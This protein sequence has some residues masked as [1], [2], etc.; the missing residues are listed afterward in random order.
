MVV[1]LPAELEVHRA[2]ARL[3]RS[4]AETIT[5]DNRRYRDRMRV[6]M[7]VVIGPLGPAAIGFSG[8]TV[9]EAGR[10]V[11]SRPDRAP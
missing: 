6:R 4:A 3:I 7:A 1:F 9:V 10:L 11:D 2:L 8:A 5:E